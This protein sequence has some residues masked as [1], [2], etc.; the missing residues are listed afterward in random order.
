MDDDLMRQ[1]NEIVN[2]SEFSASDP[3]EDVIGL[4]SSILGHYNEDN[5]TKIIVVLD[6]PEHLC[7]E[8]TQ[9]VE[10][11]D[12]V[13]LLEIAKGIVVTNATKPPRDD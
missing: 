12:V 1:V 9:N 3:T 5:A 6:T 7:V 13:F 8:S 11:R 10:P 4:I 2:K